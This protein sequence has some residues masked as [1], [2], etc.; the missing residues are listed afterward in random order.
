MS[1]GILMSG[2]PPRKAVEEHVI[3]QPPWLN[4]LVELVCD[5]MSP[6]GFVGPLG[7]SWWEPG[8]PHN[9]FDGWTLAVYPTPGE[10]I[11]G[12]NDGCLYVNGFRL[13]VTRIL[14]A[15][16]RVESVEWNAPTVYTQNFDGP[17]II[18]KGWLVNEHVCIRVFNIPPPNEPAAFSINQETGEVTER[19]MV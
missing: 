1:K 8:N 19:P 9:P 14:K 3:D 4:V 18:V 10:A 15:L 16:N 6:L 7:Y 13:D 5:A 11:G 17:E 12:S 2:S